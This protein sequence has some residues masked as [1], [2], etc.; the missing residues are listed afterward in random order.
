MR[1]QF[2]VQCLFN[3]YGLKKAKYLKRLSMIDK[4][5]PTYGT[6]W[7]LLFISCLW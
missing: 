6:D 5:I 1:K 3:E 4:V 2:Y 7:A